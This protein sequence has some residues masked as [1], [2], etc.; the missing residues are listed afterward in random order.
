M[1]FKNS[2]SQTCLAKF[3]LFYFLKTSTCK[4]LM[5]VILLNEIEQLI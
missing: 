2:C 4:F 1:N 5:K 3:T